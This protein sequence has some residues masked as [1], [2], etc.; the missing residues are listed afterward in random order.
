VENVPFLEM[1]SKNY[2]KSEREK[3][4]ESRDAQTLLEYLMNKEA[5]DPLLFH[6]VQL[7]EEQGRIKTS[8]GP[9]VRQLWIT[10]SLVN[11]FLYNVPNK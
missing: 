1:D 10:L 8:F 2:M 6:D 11:F 9:M 5:E 4:L 3:Y 7:D